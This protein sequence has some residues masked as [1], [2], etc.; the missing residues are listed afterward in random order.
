MTQDLITGWQRFAKVWEGDSPQ[1][2]DDLVA[3]DVV[4]RIPPFPD[5]VG[6][7]GVKDFVAAFRAGYPNMSVASEEDIV[8][9]DTSVHRWY[10]E[11]T[12]SGDSPL[13]PVGATGKRATANG[14]MIFHWSNGRIADAWHF[15][16]WLGW[17]TQS[18]VIEGLGSG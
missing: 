17:L 5:I 3:A 10:V 6:L 8:A 18:G 15:G 1:V 16:D 11:A 14:T 4:Y 12:L 7:Q 9:G 2:L 13:L